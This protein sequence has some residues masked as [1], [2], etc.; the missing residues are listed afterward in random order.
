MSIVIVDNI[1][2]NI[3]AGLNRALA[4]ASG[5]YIIRLDAHCIPAENYVELCLND[6]KEGKGENVGGAWVIQPGN[7]TL[8]AK[9]ISLAAAHPL[10][11]GDAKYRHGSEAGF[12]DTVPF[13][14]FRKDIFDRFGLFDERLLTNEDYEFNSRLRKGGARIWFNPEIKSI[15]FSRTTLVDLARQYWRYGFWKWLMLRSYPNTLRFRQALPP[16]FILSIIGL[17]FLCL[18]VPIARYAL[19]LEIGVYILA[20]FIG[21][22]VIKYQRGSLNLWIGMNLAIISMHFSWGAGFLW[23]ILKNGFKAP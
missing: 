21:T 13:G 2:R 12:V 17:V 9:A 16:L 7:E 8:M 4:S 10:G 14:S 1:K 6:I 19:L 20:I 5:E 15:Y 3:P 18:R 23:S 11:V 22:R